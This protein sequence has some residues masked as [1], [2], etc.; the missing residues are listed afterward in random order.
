MTEIREIW[1]N[2]PLLFK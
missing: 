2:K 1:W